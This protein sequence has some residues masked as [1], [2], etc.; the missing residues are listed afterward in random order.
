MNRFNGIAEFFSTVEHK[1][2]VLAAQKVGMTPSGVS[3]AVSRLGASSLSGLAAR[4]YRSML[5]S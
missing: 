3:K 4:N 2:F 5:M 1:S